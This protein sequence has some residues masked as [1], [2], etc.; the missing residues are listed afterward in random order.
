MQHDNQQTIRPAEIEV[1]PD[2]GLMRIVWQDDHESIYELAALRP[3][4][5]C[6]HCRG[7][8]GAPGAVSDATVFSKAQTTLV[9]M[10]EVGRYALQPI[11]A[12]GHQTGYYTFTQL[13]SLCPC[14]QCRAAAG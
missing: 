10:H 14:A 7:E 8:M 2:E 5:P 4:C 9:D 11:W 1:D 13:R 6:A 12:D 3:H